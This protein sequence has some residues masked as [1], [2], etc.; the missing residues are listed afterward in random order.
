MAFATNEDLHTYAPEVFDQGVDDW[1]PDLALAETDVSN[2][3]R[4]NWYNKY[5]DP[6][7]YDKSKLTESQWTKATVY[8]ALYAY[9]LP[10]LSTFRPEGDPFMMQLSFYKERF[11]EEFDIQFGIGVDYDENN[12]GTVSD[13][14]KHRL[15]MDRLYR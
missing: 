12:D 14:E 13:T 6:N 7:K 1:A 15:S 4:I 2:Q 10:K 9:I 3:I 8:K 5:H 11:A